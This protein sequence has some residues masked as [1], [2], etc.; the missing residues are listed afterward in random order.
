[1]KIKNGNV[2]IGEFVND[3]KKGKGKV[4]FQNQT[5]YMG[6]MSDDHANGFGTYTVFIDGKNKKI[7]WDWTNGYIN[8]C[9]A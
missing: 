6:Y 2:Y 9:L 8:L 4:E 5:T 7:I 1:M 3:I